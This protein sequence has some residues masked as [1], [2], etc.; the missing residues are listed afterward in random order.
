VKTRDCMVANSAV[1]VPLG[2][3]KRGVL[4]ALSLLI[5]FLVLPGCITSNAP[6]SHEVKQNL[7]NSFLFRSSYLLFPADLVDEADPPLP[8]LT[9]AQQKEIQ[10]NLN[11]LARALVIQHNGVELSLSK[12]LQVDLGPLPQDNIMVGNRDEPIAAAQANGQIWVDVKV[13]QAVFRSAL[14]TGLTRGNSFS[15]P[16]AG[17]SVRLPK[18]TVEELMTGMLSEQTQRQ[19]LD[20]FLEMRAQV[21]QTEGHNLAVDMAD[22]FEGDGEESDWE[23]M[24]NLGLLS[25]PVSTDYYNT[26]LFLLAHEQGHL[27]LRHLQDRKPESDEQ[28]GLA[29]HEADLYAFLLLASAYNQSIVPPFLEQEL[30]YAL[31]YQAFFKNAYSIVGFHGFEKTDLGGYPTRDE[32][33]GLLDAVFERYTSAKHDQFEAALIE[34]EKKSRES[35]GE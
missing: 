13:V 14:A 34:A 2:R 21:R 26:L 25:E 3:W 19:C 33:L 27:A 22:S 4:Y 10:K 16:L 8:E 1:E 9:R 28:R 20:L 18:L 6:S 35:T 32:R 29:E 12:I 31:G 15:R 23:V 24:I 5:P 7:E 30:G 17:D 11:T